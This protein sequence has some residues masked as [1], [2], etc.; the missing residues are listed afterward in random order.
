MAKQ[1]TKTF[2]EAVESTAD[3]KLCYHKGIQALEHRHRMKIQFSDTSQCNGSL[4]IDKCV[5]DQKKY[6]QANTW[7]YAV[8][9]KGEVFFVEVHSANTS[10]VRT[11]LRK[12]EWLKMWLRDHA[13]E[14]EKLK[15]KS[16]FPFYWI[17]SDRFDIAPNSAQL[18]E[19]IQKKLKPIPKLTLN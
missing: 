14:I 19:A 17:Q 5:T 1:K 10:E 8:A 3:V 12:L 2:K 16:K 13:P 18:R 11:V 6:P 15:A 4:F 9:Y 7:D